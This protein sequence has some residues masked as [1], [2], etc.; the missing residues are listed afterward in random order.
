MAE[1]I[2]P[3]DDEVV[4]ALEAQLEELTTDVQ[5]TRADF[6]NYR[7][8]VDA[9]K[10]AMRQAGRADAI[11]KLLP[12]VDTIERGVGHLPETLVDDAWAQGVAKLP[13][14][15]AGALGTLGVER[16]D[17]SDGTAFDPT[18]HEAIQFDEEAE[19]EHE[20]I[21]EELQAGYLLDGS[22]IRTAMVRV[23]RR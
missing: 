16:I 6:E 9:E 15:L 12:I 10:A 21:A 11:K 22:P 1:Q 3:V 17:A 18:L 13:K 4:A 14:T 23:T 7:K 19:G 5:R 2:Q 8:R 20:V